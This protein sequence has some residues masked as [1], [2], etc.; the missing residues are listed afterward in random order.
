MR[1]GC[2]TEFL[3]VEQEQ[4]R[5]VL[6]LSLGFKTLDCPLHILIDFLAIKP[7]LVAKGLQQRDE[8]TPHG[9][10]EKPNTCLAD[11]DH[12]LPNGYMKEK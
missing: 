10:M 7:S 12:P 2:A 4:K 6:L 9:E 1:C 11:Q 5:H 3:P 8:D